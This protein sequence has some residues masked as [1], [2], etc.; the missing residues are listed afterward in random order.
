MF[1]H[2]LPFGASLNAF[3]LPR[4]LPVR[5]DED[6]FGRLAASD[7]ECLFDTAVLTVAR[8]SAPG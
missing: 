8:L 6:D 2:L 1:Q 7:G 3:D 4:V 5:I